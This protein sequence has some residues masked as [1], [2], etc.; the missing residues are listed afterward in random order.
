MATAPPFAVQSGYTSEDSSQLTVAYGPTT[1]IISVCFKGIEETPW[2]RR[3]LQR[4]NK[5]PL[6]PSDGAVLDDSDFLIDRC[7]TLLLELADVASIQGLAVEALCHSPTYR[8]RLLGSTNEAEAQDTPGTDGIRITGS[9]HVSYE[10]SHNLFPLLISELPASCAAIPRIPASDLILATAEGRADPRE[11]ANIQGKVILRA[12]A[13]A[14]EGGSGVG[15][16]M[17]FKPSF[18]RGSQFEREA[19]IL[20]RIAE[21]D[22]HKE[23]RF[24][25]LVGLVTTSPS[26]DEDQNQEMAVVGML[27][28]LIPTGPNGGNFL[29]ATVQARKDT[30]PQWKAEVEE[31]VTVLHE[32]DL[33]WGDVNA[34]NVVIDEADTAWVIDFGGSNNAEFVDDELAETKEGDWQGV[35]RLFAV[36]LVEPPYHSGE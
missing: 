18:G 8:L 31:M 35:G 7:K 17:Y 5:K 23:Y 13:A 12:A 19:Q 1:F 11:A 34:G 25:Q 3:Y 28:H 9:D 29:S 4:V 15:R 21:L 22:L 36:W 33:V 16:A 27:L 24:S 10:P 20:G 2:G 14:E 26:R 30:F 32:H 6:D